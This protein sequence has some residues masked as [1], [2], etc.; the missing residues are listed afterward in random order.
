VA[1]DTDISALLSAWEGQFS[2]MSETAGEAV[3]LFSTPRARDEARDRLGGGVRGRF[4]VTV[5]P[6]AEEAPQSKPAA[7]RPKAD[8]WGDEEPARPAARG[9][10]A[11]PRSWERIAAAP[12]PPKPA[13]V[14]SVLGDDGAG[15]EEEEE[16][17]EESDEDEDEEAAESEQADG[18]GECT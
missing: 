5:P 7:A 16:G 2:L 13:N 10:K 14:W 9:A 11:A 17:S 6:A 15:E 1:P 12:A 4:T 18:A 8:A 3:A